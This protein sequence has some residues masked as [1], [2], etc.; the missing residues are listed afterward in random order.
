MKCAEI[1]DP[2]NTNAFLYLAA[3]PAVL[4]IS[5]LSYR[6]FERPF[7]QLKDR[8]AIVKNGTV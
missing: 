1:F 2:S 3:L 5:A 4:A 7:L 6:Y 8:L